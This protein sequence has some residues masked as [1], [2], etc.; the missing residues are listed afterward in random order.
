MIDYNSYYI[1]RASSRDKQ[2]M[3]QVEPESLV[4]ELS[5]EE[6]LK[7]RMKVPALDQ[8]GSIKGLALPSYTGVVPES[9]AFGKYKTRAAVVYYDSKRFLFQGATKE[10][11]AFTVSDPLFL[12]TIRS[13]HALTDKEKHLAEGQRVRM[14]R[15]RVSDT[16]AGLARTSSLDNDSESILRLIND[17]FPDGE[18]QA[19][20][21]IKIIE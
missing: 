14:V 8:A 12:A 17:K 1:I 15:A 18:P 19:G 9:P 16:F 2:A 4:K 10:T 6:F 11:G 5:P 7:A 21:S 3:L 20:E 13:L